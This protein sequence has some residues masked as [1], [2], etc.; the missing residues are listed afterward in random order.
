[1]GYKQS[2]RYGHISILFDGSVGMGIHVSMSG[3]GCREFE[4]QHR[5]DP[6]LSLFENVL[7]HDGQF[8]RLDIAVDNVDGQL[9][10]NRLEDEINAKNIRSRFKKGRKISE[11]NLCASGNDALGKTLYVGSTQSR[12][13]IRF[14][15][16][17]AQLGIDQHWTR[18]EIQLRSER[19]Q[20]AAQIYCNSL[21][22]AQIATGIMNT[23]FTV[24]NNDDSNKSRCSTQEWWSNWLAST[25]KLKLSIDKVK[26][27]VLQVADYIRRQYAPSLAMLKEYFQADFSEFIR[28][29]VKEGNDRMSLKHYQMLASSN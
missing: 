2:L 13:Q 27:T 24:I 9:D 7:A 25:E 10:L 17:A 6:W 20:V 23:Y 22:P 14:Y 11:F 1:M 5:S 19:A 15:D 28:G 16:K 3:Q 26:K 12:L 29:I 18:A 8:T 21:E 4:A